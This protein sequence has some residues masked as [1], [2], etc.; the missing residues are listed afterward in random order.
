MKFLLLLLCGLICL[1]Y[2]FTRQQLRTNVQN[3]IENNSV[4]IGMSQTEAKRSL[5]QPLS[6]KSTL[7]AIDVTV[8]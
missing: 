5:G 1:G 7:G 2:V 4:V 6:T 3:A 8:V